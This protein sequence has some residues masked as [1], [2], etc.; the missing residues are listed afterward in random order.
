MVCIILNRAKGVGWVFGLT[1][2]RV[3]TGTMFEISPAPS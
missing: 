2:G 1:W 3:Y